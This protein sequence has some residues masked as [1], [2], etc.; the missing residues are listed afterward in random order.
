MANIEIKVSNKTASTNFNEVVSFNNCDRL[1]FTFDGEW[2]QFPVRIAVAVWADGC[3]EQ[4]FSGTECT[5]PMIGENRSDFVLIGVFA[6]SGEKRIA[7]TFVRLKCHEGAHSVRSEAFSPTVQEQILALINGHDWSIFEE[8]VAAGSYSAV[9]VNTCG[10]VIKGGKIVE[11]GSEGQSAPTEHLAEG[12]LFFQLSDGNFTPF[13]KTQ[14]GLTKLQLSGGMLNNSL[15]VGN[16]QFNGSEPVSLTADDLGLSAVATSG[17]Y[18]DLT[19]KPQITTGQV[20]S[21]NGKT[22]DVA[23]S[24]EDLGLGALTDAKQMPIAPYVVYGADYNNHK[25]T[26]FVEIFG[27]ED[28]PTANAP[29]SSS[30][31]SQ[32][33]G[34]WYMLI[35]GHTAQ[36]YITQIAFSVRSDCAMRI[37]NYMNGIWSDWKALYN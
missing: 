26:G 1:K 9:E 11:F 7:S 13:V 33:N 15:T 25:T 28:Y 34:D 6:V 32:T 14:S 23:I 20:T 2:A 29:Q 19:N 3:S 36:N 18:N 12:G 8:K 35:L 37:R 5:F 4:T 17:D 24:K 27:A 16:K 21:V 30:N 22:G 31:P 10:Q